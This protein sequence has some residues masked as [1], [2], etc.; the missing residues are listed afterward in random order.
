[1]PPLLPS[2]EPMAA[3]AAFLRG[4]RVAATSVFLFVI[5]VTYVGFGA[6]CHDFGFSLGW[7]ELSTLLMWA[8]P[9]QVILVTALG[10]G[11][12]LIE[13]AITVGLSSVRL[14]P[15]VVALLPL[16][17][18]L[19]TPA[20]RLVVPAH[21]IAV[22]MWVEAMRFAPDV[23]RENRLSFCGGI[24]VGLLA[25]AQIA[26]AVG[27]YLSALLPAVFAAAAIFVT[28]M[29]FL[30]S[31]VRNSRML[32]ERLAFALALVIGPLLA[33]NEVK[34]DLLWT[35]IVAGTIA[36]AVHRVRTALS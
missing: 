25:A 13:T 18:G 22:S 17:R 6:L 24:G 33:L 1:M 20:W 27:F 15:M 29:S 26:T 9:A 35:G 11:A 34:L 10:S 5:T 31:V 23:P 3:L 14:L 16:V 36:Y 21:F 7:A 8:A 19:R 4:L 12:P 32:L 30:V 2:P 28:P